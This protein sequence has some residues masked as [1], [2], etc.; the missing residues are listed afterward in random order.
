MNSLWSYADSKQ[1]LFQ[2]TALHYQIIKS[3]QTH[4]IEYFKL[5][6]K[7]CN[8]ETNSINKC[9]MEL[10]VFEYKWTSDYQILLFL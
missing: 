8:H 1:K 9:E 7:Q 6:N 4:G 2:P 5:N 3:N 10:L